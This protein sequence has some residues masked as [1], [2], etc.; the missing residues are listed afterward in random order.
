LSSFKPVDV[1]DAA[2]TIQRYLNRHPKAVETVEGVTKWWLLRQR[3]D[4]SEELVQQ[5]LD[6][7]ERRGIVERLKMPGGKVMYRTAVEAGTAHR[8]M[9]AKT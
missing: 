1:K 5:A 7:L 8:L 4:D 2:A 3:Y 9:R 6:Y